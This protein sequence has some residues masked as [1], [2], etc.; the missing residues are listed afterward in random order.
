[1]INP[2]KKNYTEKELETFR[3]LSAIRVFER[4]SPDELSLFMPYLHVRE[5]VQNEVVFF[6]NDPSHALY[7]LKS[8]KVTL[9]FEN[10]DNYEEL[11][12][13]H[14]GR[15]FGDNALLVDTQRLYTA[16]VLSEKAS[17]Y[18]LP[19]VNVL[20]IFD[21]NVEI[22]AKMITSLAEEYNWYM[23]KIFKEYRSSLGFFSLRGA[24]L[25]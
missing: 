16:I 12:V 10:G 6:R 18:V 21:E 2:F 22:K 20:E 4:L 23:E 13:L 9:N 8:G 5:Y 1:M 17:M 11:A 19:Q 25:Q 3:F 14:E 7:I 15:A 24:M